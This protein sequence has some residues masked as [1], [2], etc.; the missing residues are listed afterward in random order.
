MED[1]D[2]EEIE[3]YGGNKILGFTTKLTITNEAIT[4]KKCKILQKLYKN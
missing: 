4:Q 1:D 3:E 2:V